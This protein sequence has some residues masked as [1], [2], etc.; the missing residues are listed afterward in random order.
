VGNSNNVRM[1]QDVYEA[2]RV[3]ADSEH[4]TITAQ[5]NHMLREHLAIAEII[6]SNAKGRQ[7]ISAETSLRGIRSPLV[8]ITKII[9]D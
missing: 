8:G 2:L 7:P 3:Y 6:V 9:R 1:D 5:L 4:R